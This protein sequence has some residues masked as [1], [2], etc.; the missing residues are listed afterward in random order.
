MNDLIEKIEYYLHLNVMGKVSD[1]L[2][3]DYI[4]A[5]INNHTK[6]VFI[7]SNYRG[8]VETNVE[9]ALYRCKKATTHDYLPI[10]QHLY[11]PQFLDD[12]NPSERESGIT[13]GI[14]IL[15]DCDELWICSENVS[16]GMKQEMLYAREQGIPIIKKVGRLR[17]S[18]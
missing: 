15:N 5:E 12:D 10:A 16:D 13:C 14:D 18:Q 4:S 7:C 2:T 1:R 6:K 3:L 11:F 9:N 8:D 17:E